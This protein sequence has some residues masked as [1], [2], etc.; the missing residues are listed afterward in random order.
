MP[1]FIARC[2]PYLAVIRLVLLFCSSQ[3]HRPDCGGL[4]E[5]EERSVGLGALSHF[6]AGRK[7]ITSTENRIVAMTAM[8]LPLSETQSDRQ[9][10]FWSDGIRWFTGKNIE[11]NKAL[12]RRGS[13]N[14]PC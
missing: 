1:D 3:P 9:L 2:E 4:V 12:R 11:L 14:P 7:D 13:S 6:V 10:G 5:C 8:R